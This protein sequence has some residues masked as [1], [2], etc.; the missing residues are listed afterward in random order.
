[1]VILTRVKNAPYIRAY[2]FLEAVHP[3]R[4][5]NGHRLLILYWTVER[6]VR[7]WQT[8]HI[9]V[10][11]IV[12]ERSYVVIKM[13][14]AAHD[15]VIVRFTAGL[16]LTS[17][18]YHERKP[19]IRSILYPVLPPSRFNC[20]HRRRNDAIR[21]LCKRRNGGGRANVFPKVPTLAM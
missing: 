5:E 21:I 11:K 14:D 13:Q 17:L 16:L 1:M 9:R 10:G 8:E 2:R 3:S 15:A 12:P 6:V 19:F 4:F 18:G 20:R 7:Y